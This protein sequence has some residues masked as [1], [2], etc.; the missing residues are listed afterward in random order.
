MFALA[1]DLSDENLSESKQKFAKLTAFAFQRSFSRFLRLSKIYVNKAEINRS[2][3]QDGRRD[4]GGIDNI[5]PNARLI[6]RLMV[7]EWN[8]IDRCVVS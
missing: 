3:R 2:N 7:G 6:R 8:P 1:D 4:F 5:D